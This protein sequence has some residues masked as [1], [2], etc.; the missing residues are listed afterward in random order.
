MGLSRNK[1]AV[2][3]G[4]AG[5][6]PF[7]GE[8]SRMFVRRCAPRASHGAVV[9]GVAGVEE[10]MGFRFVRRGMFRGSGADALLGSRIAT[11]GFCL[12]RFDARRACG[13]A[14]CRSGRRGGAWWLENWIVDASK[15]RVF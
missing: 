11:P 10:I 12:A 15:T 1:V 8:F 13:P 3:E 5:S 4:A 2:P 9:V 14:V 7:Y 6:P